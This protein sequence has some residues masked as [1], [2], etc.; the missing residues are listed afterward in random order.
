[1]LSIE[2]RDATGAVIERTVDGNAAPDSTPYGQRT[3]YARFVCAEAVPA[4]AACTIAAGADECTAAVRADGWAWEKQR[5][6]GLRTVA[7]TTGD[8]EH[9]RPSSPSPQNPSCSSV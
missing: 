6:I 2:V 9:R 5:L 7:A 3:Q 4:L 1:M 8:G